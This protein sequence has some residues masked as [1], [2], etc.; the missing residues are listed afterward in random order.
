MRF[1]PASTRA[2]FATGLALVVTNALSGCGGRTPGERSAATPSE[3]PPPSVALADTG[4][5]PIVVPI[6]ADGIRAR[7]RAAGG[8]TVVNLWATWCAPCRAE[9]P[10]LLRVAQA[11]RDDGVRLMLVSVDFEDQLGGVRRF[12]AEQSVEDTTFVKT[13]DDMGFINGVH[14]DWSGALPATLV[15]DRSGRL[16]DFWEGAAD[17]NRF[18]HAVIAALAASPRSEA[19]P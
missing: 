15:Y 7:A 2:I 4:A 9:M 5:D 11:H 10:A 16:S 18:E 8:V 12:L 6:G 13:G 1:P 17:E 14:R 3:E 19:R